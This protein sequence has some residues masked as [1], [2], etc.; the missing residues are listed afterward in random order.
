MFTYLLQFNHTN[1]I[2]YGDRHCPIPEII[3]STS[4]IVLIV[5]TSLFLSGVSLYALLFLYMKYR[6]RQ[7]YDQQIDT[8]PEAP[9][10]PLQNSF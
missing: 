2:W 1:H 4:E 6:E 8:E 5:I 9:T 7:M 10:P 3:V